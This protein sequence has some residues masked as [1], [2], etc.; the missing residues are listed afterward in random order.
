MKS[1][2]PQLPKPPSGAP[3]ESTVRRWHKKHKEYLCNKTLE[4]EHRKFKIKRHENKSWKTYWQPMNRYTS[5]SGRLREMLD[6]R[7]LNGLLYNN[8]PTI[9]IDRN[10]LTRKMRETYGNYSILHFRYANNHHPTHPATP[11]R[12]TTNAL[13]RNTQQYLLQTAGPRKQMQLKYAKA[14]EPHHLLDGPDNITKLLCYWYP[15]CL[16]GPPCRL[17]HR[18]PP[19][20]SS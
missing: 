8:N 12:Q 16:F 13:L 1:N 6:A 14:D 19:P 18:P 7:D 17:T 4:I 2:V 3:K 15:F 20:P 9:I 5:I 10:S 11:I